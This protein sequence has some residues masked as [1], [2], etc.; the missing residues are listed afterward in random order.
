VLRLHGVHI[1][2]EEND[3]ELLI[4]DTITA[5]TGINIGTAP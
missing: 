3:T 4:S 2:E 5:H 1:V